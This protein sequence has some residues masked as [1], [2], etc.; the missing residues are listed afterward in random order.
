MRIAGIDSGKQR[1]SFAVVGIE[2][3]NDNIFVLGVKTWI[4]RKYL[5]VENLI[6]NIHDSQPFNFY[7]IEINNTGEHVY[8][9]LKYR[10]KIP[11]IVPVFTTAELKD[12]IKIA[13]GKVMPKNQ[14]VRYMSS[15]FQANRI[16]FPTK[17]NPHIEELKRQISNFS[18]H[19]TEAGNVSYYA[20]GTEH[21]DTVMALMLAIFVGRHYIKKHEGGQTKTSVESKKFNMGSDKDMLGTGVPQGM[22]RLD[23]SVHMP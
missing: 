7:V 16:K 21:D 19:I 18:E 20:E 3:K 17:T 23:L 5:E 1:D 6:A 11:N 8:E 14:M 13:A 22:E 9:E 2:I 10:H 15:M 4:G 12:Q